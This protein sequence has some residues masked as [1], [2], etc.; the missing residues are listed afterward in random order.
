MKRTGE[1]TGTL[2]VVG[3]NSRRSNTHYTMVLRYSRQVNPLGKYKSRV[4]K[5]TAEH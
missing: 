5:S 4:S 1:S 3:T 2:E